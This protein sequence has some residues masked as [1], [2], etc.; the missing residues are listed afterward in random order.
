MKIVFQS[1][2]FLI[3][4]DEPGSGKI[5]IINGIPVPKEAGYVATQDGSPWS[6]SIS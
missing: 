3:L 2:G 6:V 4:S 5:P 1:Y